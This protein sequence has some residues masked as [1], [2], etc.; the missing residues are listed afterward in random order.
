M[1]TTGVWQSGLL[2]RIPN[3]ADPLGSKA[4]GGFVGSN[5]T[6]PAN[7]STRNERRQAMWQFAGTL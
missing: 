6:A 2:H 3:P 4:N 5:P 7:S 1:I